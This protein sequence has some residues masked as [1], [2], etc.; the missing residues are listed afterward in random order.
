MTLIGNTVTVKLAE[1]YPPYQAVVL[2]IGM[3]I[4]LIITQSFKLIMFNLYF[5]GRNRAMMSQ[6]LHNMMWD[7]MS[8]DSSNV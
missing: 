1:Y 4:N 6:N 7:I 8:I 3:C 2:A 5:S